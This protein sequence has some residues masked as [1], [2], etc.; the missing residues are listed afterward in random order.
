MKGEN[1][2]LWRGL[3][4]QVAGEPDSKKLLELI[5]E[6]NRLLTEK[7]KRLRTQNPS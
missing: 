5:R 2:E 1:R 6:I 4:E 7:Q 3:C